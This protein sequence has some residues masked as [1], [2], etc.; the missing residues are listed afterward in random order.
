MNAHASPAA[1]IYGT[2]PPPPEEAEGEGVIGI[3]RVM[4]QLRQAIISLGAMAMSACLTSAP[5]HRDEAVAQ[6]GRTLAY[7]AQVRR[8]LSGCLDLHLPD[9][10]TEIATLLDLIDALGHGPDGDVWDEASA[11][12]MVEMTSVR[13]A[14]VLQVVISALIRGETDRQA[15]ERE[16]IDARAKVV[17]R[18][19]DEMEEI[20]RTIH[21]ISLNAAV[22]AARA[23]G[24]SGRVFGTIAQEVRTLANRAAEVITE[25]RQTIEAQG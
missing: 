10:G 22:E 4:G 18:M 20:G 11:R 21:L 2:L 23:G 13:I 9:M 8:W 19:C 17:N 14:R 24:E 12:R 7:A 5:Q 3:L 1:T 25:G 15:H 6:I 16:M